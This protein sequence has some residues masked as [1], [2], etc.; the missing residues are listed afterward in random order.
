MDTIIRSDEEI[1]EVVNKAF[2]FREQGSPFFGMSYEDG[3]LNMLDWL[4]GNT[5][6]NP[7]DD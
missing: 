5:D 2:D 3:I 4:T 7:M 6:D 1:G